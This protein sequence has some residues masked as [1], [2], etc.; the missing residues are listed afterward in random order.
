MH[1]YGYHILFNVS[2]SHRPKHLQRSAVL[3]AV[4]ARVDQA[5][6]YPDIRHDAFRQHLLGEL[7]LFKG[8]LYLLY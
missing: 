5:V 4:G 1:T 3:H 6:E 8:F 2:F 7:F